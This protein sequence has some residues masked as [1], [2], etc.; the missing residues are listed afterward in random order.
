MYNDD[1]KKNE[2]FFRYIFDSFVFFSSR[3]GDNCLVYEKQIEKL[4]DQI[5]KLNEEIVSPKFIIEENNK[6]T[7]YLDIAEQSFIKLRDIYSEKNKDP[8]AAN[9]SAEFVNELFTNYLEPIREVTNELHCQIQSLVYCLN[10][11]RSLCKEYDEQIKKISNEL[12]GTLKRNLISKVDDLKVILEESLSEMLKATRKIVGCIISFVSEVQKFLDDYKHII[13][14]MGMGKQEHKKV[15]DL[16]ILL[17]CCKDKCV[18][19][20]PIESLKL[21]PINK[22]KTIRINV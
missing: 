10:A 18:I 21:V 19:I 22:S 4:T 16:E 12:S 20:N 2:S 13:S 3:S 9:W 8:S 15:L 14:N 7:R 5:M 17:N 1:R 11:R 6:V